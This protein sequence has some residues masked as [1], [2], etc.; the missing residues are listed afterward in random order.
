MILTSSV[1]SVAQK[2]K[3]T[4]N[5]LIPSVCILTFVGCGSD[6][7]DNPVDERDFSAG[8]LDVSNYV[9]LGDSLT[10]GFADEALYRSGQID[11]FPNILA[12]SFARTGSGGEFDQPLMNDNLGGFIGPAGPVPSLPN[13]RV[14]TNVNGS[15][16]PVPEV[17]T[18]TTPFG[19]VLAGSFHNLGVPGAR[20]FNL[21]LSGYGDWTGVEAGTANPYFARFASAP[22]ATVLADATS[23]QPTFF[24]LWIGNNDILGYATSGGVGADSQSSPAYGTTSIDITDPTNVFAP[25]ISGIV[26]AL[27]AAGANNTKG[28]LLNLPAITSIP[29]FTT[30]PFKS[31]PLGVSGTDEEKAAQ[32]ALI[33]LLN[34][35][36]AQHNQALDAA[37]ANMDITADEAERRKITIAVGVN[38]PIIADNDLDDLSQ[39]YPEIKQ[40]RHAEQG[41]FILLPVG[42]SLGTA[43]NLDGELFDSDRDAMVAGYFGLSPAFAL[44]DSLVLSANEAAEVETARTAFNATIKSIAGSSDNLIYVDIASVLTDVSDADGLSYG[45]GTVTSVFATGGAFSLD[46]VHPTAKGYAIVANTVIDNLN[47]AFSANIPRV[48][49]GA[50]TEV[51]YAP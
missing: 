36:Y 18:P 43:R 49:P 34:A 47:Q 9:A 46:G 27:T 11:S 8:E 23:K 44:A 37:L 48:D 26:N 42:P 24:T 30:V 35:E 6:D 22:G 1:S 21:T 39:G 14:L 51:F 25:T 2:L 32:Q 29:F 16:A 4:I 50:F 7:F 28:V 31:I 15:L 5:I 38:A 3:K 33:T 10:A 40:L 41:D 17:G 13:R 19:E 20:S 45:T 12:Q